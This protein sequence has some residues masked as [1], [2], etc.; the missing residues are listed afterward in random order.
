VDTTTVDSWDAC[1]HTLGSRAA[2]PE[3]VYAGYLLEALRRRWETRLIVEWNSLNSLVF[4]K[5]DEDPAVGKRVTVSWRDG[6][7]EARLQREFRDI[8]SGR[9][10]NHS[11]TPLAVIAEMVDSLLRLL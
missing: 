5:P 4:A 9:A 10:P 8:T 7:V 3:A 11:D 6:L 2:D 1:A